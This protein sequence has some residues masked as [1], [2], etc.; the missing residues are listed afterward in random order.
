MIGEVH[1]TV[2]FITFAGTTNK[3]HNVFSSV[4]PP[5][6]LSLNSLSLSIVLNTSGLVLT[7]SYE[8]GTVCDLSWKYFSQFDRFIFNVLAFQ[9]IN[10]LII[11]PYKSFSLYVV[12]LTEFY[13][14][15]YNLSWLKKEWGSYLAP[16]FLNLSMY[17]LIEITNGYTVCSFLCKEEEKL[18]IYAPI[19][20][21]FHRVTMMGDSMCQL[22]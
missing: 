18:G 8:V 15:E 19:C 13:S 4:S 1:L 14:I 12:T 22:V 16:I 20:L 6:S 3:D 10:Y 9:L 17:C 21:H 11:F 7:N 5:D 2:V